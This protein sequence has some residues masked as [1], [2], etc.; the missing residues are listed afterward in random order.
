MT[1]QKSIGGLNKIVELDEAKIGKRKYNTGRI[2]RGQWVFG[3]IERNTKKVFVLPVSNRNSET[4][5]SMIRKYVLPGTIIHTDM[6]RGYAA[7]S[8][9]NNYTHRTVNY[10]ANFVNPETGVH[11]QNI[12]RFWKDMRAN[13]PRWYTRLSFCTLF[14]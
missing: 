7:L 6:W 2:I 3:G 8:N 5:L 9:D 4:L 10:H 1:K 12:E 11:T 14:C 13:I